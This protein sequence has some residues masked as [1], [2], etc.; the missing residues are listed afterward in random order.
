MERVT[1]F[2]HI[3]TAKV[4]V[5]AVGCCL[6]GLI[7]YAYSVLGFPFYAEVL[8]PCIITVLVDIYVHIVVFSVWIAYKESSWTS[9]VLWILVLVCFSGFGICFYLV[10]EL[11][12]LSPEKPVF[13]ILFNKNTVTVKEE[14]GVRW[15]TESLDGGRWTDSLDGDGLLNGHGEGGQ[16]R[17]EQ[18]QI[19]R[20]NRKPNHNR[21]N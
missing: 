9:A 5:T 6:L 12:Y 10:R 14:D 17:S 1:R 18:E 2:S 7:I 20:H 19:N 3:I 8:T 11:S 13:F 15:W 16:N 4:I 21:H